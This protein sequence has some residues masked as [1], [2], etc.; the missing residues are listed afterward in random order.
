MF[1][2]FRTKGII[3]LSY[4]V[5][6][7]VNN[8]Q[9]LVLKSSHRMLCGVSLKIDDIIFLRIPHSYKML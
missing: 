1:Q 5:F 2:K 4:C 8:E 3:I 9:G 6:L 7:E